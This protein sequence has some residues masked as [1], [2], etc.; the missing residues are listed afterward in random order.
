MNENILGRVLAKSNC[1]MMISSSMTM[2]IVRPPL[3][4]IK[5]H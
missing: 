3:N 5:A 2:V 1:A 4:L